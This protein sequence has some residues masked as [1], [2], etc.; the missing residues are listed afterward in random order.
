MPVAGNG[1]SSFLQPSVNDDMDM[2][3][4]AA[5]DRRFWHVSPS[6]LEATHFCFAV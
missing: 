1:L 3:G 4:G 5:I 2:S 6:S